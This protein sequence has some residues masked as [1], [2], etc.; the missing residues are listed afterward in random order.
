[1]PALTRWSIHTAMIYLL[2]GL[3]SGVLYWA[4]AQWSFAP[5]LSALSPTYLHMLVIGWL[6]QLIFGVIYWMFP[7]IRKGNMRGDPRLA[8]AVFGLLN[9]GLIL[10]IVCEPW[11]AIA[12]NDVNGTGLVLSAL[13]Q[14]SAGYLLI[15][16]CWPRVGRQAK[17]ER[18]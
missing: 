13:L 16:V 18:D 10:R 17:T 7:I 11:R 2:A 12:P 4:N 8:W 6:T 3:A 1:M 9:A 14:V 15:L 5:V